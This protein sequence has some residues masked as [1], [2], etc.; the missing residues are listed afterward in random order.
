MTGDPTDNAVDVI[1]RHCLSVLALSAKPDDAW[2]DYPDIGEHDWARVILRMASLAPIPEIEE[3]R[4]AYDH[5][6]LRAEGAES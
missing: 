4:Q 3:Y 6:R 2:E 1:A 5:L